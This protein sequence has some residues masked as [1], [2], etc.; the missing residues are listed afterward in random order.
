M[1]WFF[2]RLRI[3]FRSLKTTES[4]YKI[5]QLTTSFAKTRQSINEKLSRKK[6]K[7]EDNILFVQTKLCCIGKIVERKQKVLTKTNNSIMIIPG[8]YYLRQTATSV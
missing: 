3:H 1:S 6:F 4:H 7:K 5:R 8:I 2:F